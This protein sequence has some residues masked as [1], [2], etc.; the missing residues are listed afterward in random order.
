M[1]I[2]LRKDPF[3]SNLFLKKG[4][5]LSPRTVL[6]EERFDFLFDNRWYWVVKQGDILLS[7]GHISDKKI[8]PYFGG[9]FFLLIPDKRKLVLLSE[10]ILVEEKF[11]GRVLVIG[12]NFEFIY[13]SNKFKVNQS[14]I[15]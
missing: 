1:F 13:E 8:Y 3:S 5:F 11:S 7:E 12:K 10:E 6:G 4:V 2:T 14:V 9:F 15:F